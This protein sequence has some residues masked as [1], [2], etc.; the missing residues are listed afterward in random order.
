[1]STLGLLVLSN[2]PHG[3]QCFSFSFFLARLNVSWE[4][5]EGESGWLREEGGQG[6]GDGGE[7][8]GGGG[9]GGGWAVFG[10]L[11]CLSW[12]FPDDGRHLAGLSHQAA[13]IL[14]KLLCCFTSLCVLASLI[15]SVKQKTYGSYV[16]SEW[17]KLICF[18]AVFGV[19]E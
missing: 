5:V 2:W 9:E 10:V 8:G 13:T 11:H 14:S 7:G 16:K 3:I 1:M 18:K 4:G 6:G 12:W 15:S 17:Y 19:F